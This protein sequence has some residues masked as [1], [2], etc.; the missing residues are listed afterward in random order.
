MEVFVG[1]RIVS[2]QSVVMVSKK[3]V[4][5]DLGG[6]MAIL[7]VKRGVYYGLN[8][9]GTKIWH[10]IQQPHKVCDILDAILSEFDV[11]RER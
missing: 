2:M 1:E 6:E 4:S 10:L 8:E 7:S 3:Q 5:A 9:I 11:E